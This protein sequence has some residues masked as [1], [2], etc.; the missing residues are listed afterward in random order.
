MGSKFRHLFL[1]KKL[2]RKKL[3]EKKKKAA[4]AAPKEKK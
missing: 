1:K 4:K 3:N 2:D